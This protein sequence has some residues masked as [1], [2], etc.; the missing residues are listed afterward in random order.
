MKPTRRRAPDGLGFADDDSP[1]GRADP[2]A[3]RV[4]AHRRLHDLSRDRGW[5]LLVGDPEIRGLPGRLGGDQDTH[6]DRDV[7]ARRRDDLQSPDYWWANQAALPGLGIGKA[8]VLT[9][10][11][12]S[13]AN[14][15]PAGGAI[16]DRADVL[17]PRLLGIQ[18]HECGAVRRGDR[19]L[20]HLHQARPADVGARVPRAQ[21]ASDDHLHLGGDLRRRRLGRGCGPL[22]RAVPERSVRDQ[23]REL[24]GSRRVVVPPPPP[25]AAG[26]DVGR[27]RGTVPP[28]HDRVGRTP[29]DQADL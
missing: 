28:G 27:R 11:T 2:Q 25:Q 16:A 15:L 10:T 20:E 6:A 8:A 17:D 5:H 9:Q 26:H 19:H 1:G 7:V 23:D 12:T 3:P 21:R 22:R 24:A 13:V 18:R 14:T 4:E 29:V